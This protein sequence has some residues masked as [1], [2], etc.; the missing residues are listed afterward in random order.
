MAIAKEIARNEKKNKGKP[1]VK[2]LARYIADAEK[3]RGAVYFENTL[4]TELKPAAKE[5]EAT[6]QM[7]TRCKSPLK[8]LILSFGSEQLT[9]KEVH[10]ATKTFLEKLG[11]KDNQAI[12]AIHRD[13]NNLHAHIELNRVAYNIEKDKF[14]ATKID[15]FN[16]AMHLAARKM[17]IELDRNHDNGIYLVAINKQGKKEIIRNP[18]FPYQKREARLERDKQYKE[19]DDKN[20]QYSNKASNEKGLTEKMEAVGLQS[21]KGY[22]IENLATKVKEHLAQKNA[23]WE[24]LQELL[25]KHDAKLLTVKNGMRIACISS[26]KAMAKASDLYNG[27]SKSKLEK[28]LGNFVEHNI[29]HV[30]SEIKYSKDE[31]PLK[32]RTNTSKEEIYKTKLD[33]FVSYVRQPEIRDEILNEL[34]KENV[35]WLSLHK[36]LEARGLRLMISRNGL[37][38]EPIGKFD[39]STSASSLHY[40]ITKSK[41]EKKLGQ[42]ESF[43]PKDKS[44]FD[45]KQYISTYTE[46]ENKVEN[47]HNYKTIAEQKE[48]QRL[49]EQYDLE[50]NEHYK[51]NNG[52]K[53]AAWEVQ[54]ETER[55]RWSDFLADRKSELQKKIEEAP[56]G[57][58]KL[59]RS[60][61]AAETAAMKYAMKTLRTNERAQFKNTDTRFPSWRDWLQKQSSDAAKKSYETMT[62]RSGVKQNN[63]IT[64][65]HNNSTRPMPPISYNEFKEKLSD[66]KSELFERVTSSYN[67]RN[68]TV[69]YFLKHDF[70]NDNEEKDAD[71]IDVGNKIEFSAKSSLDL[72]TVE[73]GLL[74]AAEKFKGRVHLTG[75]NEFKKVA[76]QIAIKNNIKIMNTETADYYYQLKLEKMGLKNWP[77]IDKE[78]DLAKT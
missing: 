13:T 59:V 41:L 77:K 69:E 26:P 37:S 9:N 75:S 57:V 29:E 35:T 23:S 63:A 61:H 34:K 66:Y 55:K 31:L 2:D 32:H 22:L 46:T 19:Q 39:V 49:K 27:F 17:E 30:K 38:I 11:F 40:S 18:Q 3:T 21:F 64:N 1:N 43:T 54:R 5:M 12:I 28:I 15:F 36:T 10:E 73:V 78:I 56:R 47:L 14:I 48:Q 68:L 33:N 72:E 24:S 74:I 71:F 62:S 6:M 58:N 53:A 50:R 52:S 45:L 42:Y 67:E 8:H 16:S 60:L 65:E 7:S 4:S 20:F 51:K 76:V 70:D 25:A 44:V